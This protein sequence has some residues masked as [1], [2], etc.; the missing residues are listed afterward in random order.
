MGFESGFH[1]STLNGCRH[2][3]S[4]TDRSTFESVTVSAIVCRP[5]ER[6]V[7]V[8][9]QSVCKFVKDT[10]ERCAQLMHQFQEFPV[11]RFMAP[12]SCSTFFLIF[13]E[14][15]GLTF[16]K[17]NLHFKQACQSLI[18]GF[19]LLFRLKA[20]HAVLL[21]SSSQTSLALNDELNRSIQF[22]WCHASS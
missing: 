14:A 6:G 7:F 21:L 17:P 9:V 15:P 4:T 3:F 10:V 20:V 12:L 2:S 18:K 1:A 22:F 13:V 19:E 5:A 11:E 8:S 16:E